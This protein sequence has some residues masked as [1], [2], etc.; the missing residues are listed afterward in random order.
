M[1][2]LGEEMKI[3]EVAVDN[4]LLKERKECQYHCY[5]QLLDGGLL[6]LH[7]LMG[8]YATVALQIRQ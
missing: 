8:M 2:L 3:M 1:V 7:V 6:V 4:L 5:V